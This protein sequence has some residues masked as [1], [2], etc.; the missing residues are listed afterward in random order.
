MNII[1]KIRYLLF[2]VSSILYFHNHS[3]YGDYK[4]N[5]SSEFI[6]LLS[7]KCMA[8]S[9]NTGY[10]LSIS[11]TFKFYGNTYG[12][13]LFNKYSFLIGDNCD[14]KKT[15]IQCDSLLKEEKS[16]LDAEIIETIIRYD[17]SG[18]LSEVC[19]PEERKVLRDAELALFLIIAQNECIL[20]T[21]F[22]ISFIVASLEWFMN[23]LVDKKHKL[24]PPAKAIKD[25]L[26]K[27]TSIFMSTLFVKVEK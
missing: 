26:Q 8:I 20:L 2:A 17:E 24:L 21:D 27:E 12:Q 5:F 19:R 9:K 16:R 1:L 3:L 7:Q 25:E 11:Q 6:E 10:K 14:N 22:D 18:L 15:Q 23:R 13:Y 4:L